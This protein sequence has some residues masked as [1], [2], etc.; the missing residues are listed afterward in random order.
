M[1]PHN[2]ASE[3]E[4]IRLPAEIQQP[5][6]NHRLGHTKAVPRG[7][8]GSPLGTAGLG[9]GEGGAAKVQLLFLG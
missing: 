2:A 4:Q 7:C 6:R 3:R 1:V 8:V 9:V 5:G